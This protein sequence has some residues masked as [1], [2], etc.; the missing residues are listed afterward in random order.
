[1]LLDFA[2][3]DG[4]AGGAVPSLKTAYLHGPLVDQVLAQVDIASGVVLWHLADHQGTVRDLVDDAGEVVEHIQY[5]AFGNITGVFDG[6][7]NP[8]PEASTRYGF[9][10][11]VAL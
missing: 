5:E 7:G 4:T 6:A 11:P 9:T 10:E 1:M 2:D 3:P 8:L